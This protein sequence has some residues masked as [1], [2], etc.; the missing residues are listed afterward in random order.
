M[1]E[2]RSISRRDFLVTTA[3]AAATTTLGFAANAAAPA[4]PIIDLHQHTDYGGQR[5]A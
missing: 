5:D 3:V 1:T 2:P 4:E